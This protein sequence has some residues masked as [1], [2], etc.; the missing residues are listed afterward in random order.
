MA[1]DNLKKKSSLIYSLP[2]FQIFFSNSAVI[3]NESFFT[4]FSND[5]DKRF[6][7]LLHQCQCI[8]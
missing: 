6:I 1:I 4:L 8:D 7:H 2:F 3:I 5:D